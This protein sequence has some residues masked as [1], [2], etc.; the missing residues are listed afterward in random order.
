MNPGSEMK[1][2]KDTSRVKLQ[3]LSKK[4]VL[5]IWEGGSNDIVKNN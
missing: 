1:Y 2:I 4:D 5:V 3:Q